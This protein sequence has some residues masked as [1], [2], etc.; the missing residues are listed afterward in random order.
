MN[1]ATNFLRGPVPV[2]KNSKGKV[3]RLTN[4]ELIHSQDM[5]RM[6]NALQKRLNNALGYEVQITTL[7]TIMKSITEQ[8]FFE[9]TP[10]EYLPVRVGQGA[11]SS[12]LTTYR[13]YDIFDNFETGL[14]NVGGQSA[15]LAT[16]D[17]AV[18]ALNIQ[19]FN[20]VKAIYWSIMEL[21]QASKSGN[22]DLIASKEESRKKSFDLGIQRIA[23]LGARGQNGANGSCL[24][25][26]NQT[27]ITVNTTTITQPITNMTPDQLNTFCGLVYENYRSNCQRTAKPTH[28]ILPESDYNGM[29]IPTSSQF[30][31]KS[32]LE[33]V[34]E[35]FKTMTQNPGFKV[36]PLAY[37]DAA[38]HADVA[39]IAGKQ[40]YTLLNYDEKS[41]RMDVPVPY[42]N[43]LA[44]SLNNF[45]F[46]N[47]AFC[48]FTGCLA[49]RPL[50]LL[51]FQY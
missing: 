35:I 6:V 16:A 43:T 40:V 46:E 11:W 26:L 18:D 48:Q 34:T 22:W 15:R 5:Q 32:K 45:Q 7:T 20:W 12:Q 51:Y 17:S 13:S 30:P 23:F 41:I 38:Y 49:Y 37:G 29:A 42:T 50:E 39:S 44:N 9:V 24:G 14:V 2:I 36:L 4:P 28:F 3:I 19:V 47:A 21:E 8:K 27:G 10:S 31:I 1:T 33:L 25:L